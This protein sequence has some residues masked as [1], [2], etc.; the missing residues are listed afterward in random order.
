MWVGVGM[1]ALGGIVALNGALS[2][3]GA[4]VTATLTTY[5]VDS[6]ACWTHV[7]VGA[8]VGGVGGYLFANNR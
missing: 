5:E 8:G 1:M 4:S 3:C 6:H 2:T 7:A